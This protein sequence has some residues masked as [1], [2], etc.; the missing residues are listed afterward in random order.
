MDYHVFKK[1]GVSANLSKTE[2]YT[3]KT[4][5]WIAHHTIGMLT[6]H[7]VIGVVFMLTLGVLLRSLA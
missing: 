6:H 2:Y 3:V 5:V 7:K 4:K 1:I